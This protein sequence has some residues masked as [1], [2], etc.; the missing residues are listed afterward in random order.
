MK[1]LGKIISLMSFLFMSTLVYSQK[2]TGQSNGVARQQLFPQLVEL[3]GN[4]LEV[5]NGPCQ[6]TTGWS[7]SGTHLIIKNNFDQKKINI[8]LGPS[9]EISE[10]IKKI[11]PGAQIQAKVFRT[12]ELPES[13]YI[14]KSISIDDQVIELRDANMRPFWAGHR[15]KKNE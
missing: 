3:S 6:N 15:R 2:G 9:N 7:N 4:L 10:L 14:A 8:H 13:Q 5:K 1:N 11:E 12:K